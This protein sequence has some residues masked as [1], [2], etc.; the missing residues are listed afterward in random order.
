MSRSRGLPR[1]EAASALSQVLDTLTDPVAS[2]TS[3][4]PNTPGT[5]D[6]SGTGDAPGALVSSVT[7]VPLDAHGTSVGAS[8]TS[9][10]SSE[11]DTS[12]RRPPTRRT[13]VKLRND[14]ACEVRD[15]VWFL[16]EHGRP[17]VQL[18]ELLDEA[19]EAWLAEAKKTYNEGQDFPHRGL[20]R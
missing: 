6:I 16:S 13:H 11:P 2:D 17:R 9:G 14:L 15:A 19:I 18:G 20:L 8:G 5:P 12:E 3:G 10:T 1:G 7:S 4:N